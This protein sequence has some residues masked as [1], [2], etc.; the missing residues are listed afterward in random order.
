LVKNEMKKR[1]V[2]TVIG[3]VQSVGFREF[4]H[5]K[6]LENGLTGFAGNLP[7]GKVIIIADGEEEQI[8]RF[9]LELKTPSP[10]GNVEDVRIV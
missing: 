5:R 1:A 10:P 3:K 7:D 8:A 9:I 2:I 4:V 6:A